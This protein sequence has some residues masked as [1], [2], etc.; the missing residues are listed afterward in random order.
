MVLQS[1]DAGV[2]MRDGVVGGK[3]EHKGPEAGKHIIDHNAPAAREP[4]FGGM[5]GPRLPD[6]EDAEEDKGHKQEGRIAPRGFRRE[7]A[8]EEHGYPL[9]DKLINHDTARVFAA[10]EYFGAGGGQSTEYE[11]NGQNGKACGQ[12]KGQKKE[13][14]EQD[15]EERTRRARRFGESPEGSSLA[16]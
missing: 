14:G 8:E 9:A 11:N 7:R 1:D 12:A 2:E 5:H 4:A 3:G 15:G 13:G 6:I 16:K 10:E